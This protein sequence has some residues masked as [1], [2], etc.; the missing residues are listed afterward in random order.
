VPYIPPADR[1]AMLDRYRDHLERLPQLA[2]LRFPRLDDFDET[3]R[4]R[5]G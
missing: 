4:P 1:A 2:P 3:L 5:S